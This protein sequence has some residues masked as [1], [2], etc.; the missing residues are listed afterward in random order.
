V[1]HTPFSQ[2]FIWGAL[3]VALGAG[4]AI[5]AH[6][7]FVLGF[8]FPLGKG[9]ASFI[10]IHGHAQ[11]VG[12]VGLVIMGIS[13][14]FIPRL[15]G[16]PIARPQWLNRILCLMLIGLALR[17]IG[18]SVV[19]FLPER[20]AL[21]PVVWL[22]AVSGVFECGGMLWYAFLL[23]NTLR[24]TG[25]SRSRSAFLA[26]R[27]YFGMMVTGWMLYACLNLVLLLHMAL[28]KSVVLDQAWNQFAI[29]SFV[30][31]VLLPVAF[32]FSVRMLP[33]YL[34][35]ARPDWPVHGTAYAYCIALALQVLP[36]APPF[37]RM[38]PHVASGLSNLGMVLK[39]G[40]ILWFVWQLD[41]LTR[42][43]NPWTVHRELHPGPE[44][45]PTR[46]GLPDYGEFGRFERLVYAA[47]VWLVMAATSEAVS[48]I[49]GLV[50]GPFVIHS[51]AVRHMYLLGFATLLIFGMAARM[52][53]G[54]LQKRRVAS[55]TLVN[56]TFW[57]GNAAV[58]GRILLLI[59]PAVVLQKVP[60][61]LV[62][63]K[64]AFGV[65]G[66]FGLAAVG[67]LGVNVWKTGA[68]LSR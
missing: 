2:G 29:Q 50:N 3:L 18:H 64:A 8:D 42:R 28:D 63:A 43:R 55:Y 7:T 67:C 17:S 16:V 34:R 15:A 22:V 1:K 62:V 58:V 54:F 37:R 68:I 23:L 4:F 36:T 53:P 12:W 51:D 66:L 41:V 20:S 60:G 48:G 61:S 65:S 9:F 47:Y 52:L 59:L 5:G 24:G 31:L 27:P 57:L 40:V 14:H 39:G 11:L 33:L 56:A 38:V 44:R 13:L 46:P 10:Q 21:V 6:M 32:A 45:R 19:P 25:N 35:L 30:G 26:V 49:A